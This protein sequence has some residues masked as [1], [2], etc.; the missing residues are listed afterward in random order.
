MNDLSKQKRRTKQWVEKYVK[1]LF[2]RPNN[3]S[4]MTSSFVSH[5]QKK[6]FYWKYFHKDDVACTRKIH[7]NWTYSQ[8]CNK[9]DTIKKI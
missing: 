8:L 6:K 1:P 3:F 4:A 9:R 2:S 7:N 5:K